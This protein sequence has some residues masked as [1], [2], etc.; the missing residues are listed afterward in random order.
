MPAATN[1]PRDPSPRSQRP[2]ACALDDPE[3][4]CDTRLRRSPPPL[5]RFAENPAFDPL[6][7]GFLARQPVT[8]SCARE[9]A[10]CSTAG[11]AS[12]RPGGIFA[13]RSTPSLERSPF[14]RT[15][16]TDRRVLS[17]RSQVVAR[18]RSPGQAT[19]CHSM[20]PARSASDVADATFESHPVG[21]WTAVDSQVRKPLPS[22][23]H[24]CPSQEGEYVI[25]R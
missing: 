5:Y 1:H 21:W 9:S 25:R 11:S 10:P 16:A 17:F 23:P 6:N 24:R 19:R 14:H 12:R 18:R 15:V 8:G 7:S 3:T 13:I 4:D 2:C 20:G 22:I